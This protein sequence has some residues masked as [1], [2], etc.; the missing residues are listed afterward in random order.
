MNDLEIS[1]WNYILSSVG[2]AYFSGLS[3]K[4]LWQ[5]VEISENREQ[6]DTAVETLCKLKELTNEHDHSCE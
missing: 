3:F 4:E 6:L 2:N 1:D 5:C